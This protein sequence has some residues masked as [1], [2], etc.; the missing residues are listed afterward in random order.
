MTFSRAAALAVWAAVCIVSA[1][2]PRG[3][4]EVQY[5]VRFLGAD[6]AVKARRAADDLGCVI[7]HFTSDKKLQIHFIFIYF[8]YNL[9]RD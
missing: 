4:D 5:A 6:H 9:E 1:T 3:N 2:T 8:G 7:E